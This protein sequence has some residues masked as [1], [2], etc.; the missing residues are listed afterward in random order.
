[1]HTNADALSKMPCKQ[2][3]YDNF[4]GRSL[5]SKGQLRS[6]FIEKDTNSNI[7]QESQE[8]DRNIALVRSWL[9]AT[10]RPSFNDVRS[11]EYFLKAQ[12]SQLK[13]QD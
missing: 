8:A 6:V 5:I 9:K 1:M 13:I 3:G 10:E 4:N 11:A 7:V 2:C 12:C